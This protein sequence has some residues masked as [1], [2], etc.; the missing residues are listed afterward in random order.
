MIGHHDEGVEAEIRVVLGRRGPN[1]MHEAPHLVK[2]H[3]PIY[4]LAECV[5]VPKTL[6]GHQPC[7]W[8]RVVVGWTP[9]RTSL[10]R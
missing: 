3:L 9:N 5:Q 10:M 2:D 4:D 1:L 6:D 8:A 7:A